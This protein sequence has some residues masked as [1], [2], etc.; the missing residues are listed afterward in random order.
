MKACTNGFHS[1]Y[2]CIQ[3]MSTLDYLELLD[4][5]R[6]LPGGSLSGAFGSLPTCPAYFVN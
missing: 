1:A 5:G 4:V 3:S 6:R 2:R